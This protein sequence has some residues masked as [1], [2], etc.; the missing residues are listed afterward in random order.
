LTPCN[1]FGANLKQN[2]SE[3]LQWKVDL[4]QDIVVAVAPVPG[5]EVG[6]GSSLQCL[7]AHESP[8]L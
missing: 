4:Q 7:L 1:K 5:L 2:F 8:E 3:I 6:L